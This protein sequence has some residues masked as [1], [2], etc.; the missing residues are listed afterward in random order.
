MGGFDSIN[1]VDLVDINRPDDKSK[2]G[3]MG[4]KNTYTGEIIN[5]KS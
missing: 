4:D 5:E 1:Y 2:P 3:F